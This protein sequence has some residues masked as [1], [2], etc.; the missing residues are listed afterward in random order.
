LG[1]QEIRDRVDHLDPMDRR[2]RQE[3]Q[4]RIAKGGSG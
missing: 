1:R 3:H 2:E 4:R